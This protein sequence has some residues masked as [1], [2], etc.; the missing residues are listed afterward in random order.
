MAVRVITYRWA[1]LQKE[2][3]DA[4]RADGSE[5]Q[6]APVKPKVA[7]AR[8]VPIRPAPN[9]AP[10][11]AM[12]N[13]KPV[14]MESSLSVQ[15]QA[16]D[17]QR[18]IIVEDNPVSSLYAYAHRSADQK[19]QKSARKTVLHRSHSPAVRM[20]AAGPSVLLPAVAC[21]HAW[22]IPARLEIPAMLDRGASFH[23]LLL[24]CRS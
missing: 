1:C 23:L 16:E 4:I 17:L 13:G 21:P 19:V 6:R 24:L 20:K 10:Q 2:K 8:A 3:E 12:V 22:H 15:A 18:T 7:Q 5:P 11:L 9:M 14:I